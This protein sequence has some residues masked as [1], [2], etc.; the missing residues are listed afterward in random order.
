MLFLRANS[1]GALYNASHCYV[2]IQSPLIFDFDIFRLTFFVFIEIASAKA[3]VS[4]DTVFILAYVA[5][6]R[7]V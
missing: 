2:T 7:E 6:S 1:A 3:I 4:A 5:S